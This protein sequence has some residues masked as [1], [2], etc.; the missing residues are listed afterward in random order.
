MAPTLRTH[1]YALVLALFR[2]LSKLHN[3]YAAPSTTQA[4][5]G[6]PNEYLA[7]VSAT[8]DEP[9][10]EPGSA[11]FW[12]FLLISAGLVLAGGVFAGYV[13]N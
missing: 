7:R 3:A 8:D 5:L 11:K 4:S 1:T 6:L 12:I 9:E 10:A 2:A 13:V